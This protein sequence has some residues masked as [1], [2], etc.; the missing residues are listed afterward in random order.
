MEDFG[1][2]VDS[3]NHPPIAVVTR[4]PNSKEESPEPSDNEA[5]T[6]GP[7]PKISEQYYLWLRA[8]RRRWR[9]K[10]GAHWGTPT[11]A[12][13]AAFFRGTRVRTRSQRWDIVQIRPT[14]IAGR[15]T[16]WL[17]VDSELVSVTLRIPRIFY[18]NLKS[19]PRDG[20]FQTDYYTCEKVIRNLARDINGANLYMVVVREET[21]Q[22]IEEHFVDLINDPNV[23]GVFE[24][25]A[26]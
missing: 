9:K 6:E 22:E 11:S 7:L 4:K 25:Q 21:Y 12:P 2:T 3:S 10:Q 16:L 14:K 8:M 13:V 5:T 26:G 17:S 23:D 20:L 19:P 15:F 24:Q 1:K 18:L